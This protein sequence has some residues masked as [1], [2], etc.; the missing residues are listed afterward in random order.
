MGLGKTPLE[1]QPALIVN[2]KAGEKL[3]INSLF[4]ARNK[5]KA[6]YH[7]PSQSFIYTFNANGFDICEVYVRA[8]FKQTEGNLSLPFERRTID[9]YIEGQVVYYKEAGRCGKEIKSVDELKVLEES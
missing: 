4:M 9:R 2:V 6:H 8:S 5:D 1:R 3:R 7:F